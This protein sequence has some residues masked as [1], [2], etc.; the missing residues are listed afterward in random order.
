MPTATD[1]ALAMIAKH[2]G[3]IRTGEA[4]A[5]GIHPRTLYA[6]RDNGTLIALARGLY[7]LADLPPV[8]DPDLALVAG[9]IPHGVICLISALAIHDLT[10]QIPH[11]V[12]V[13]IP[14][15]ARYPVYAG[16]PL[17]IYRFALA[18]Y[19]AGV[20]RHNVD[21]VNTKVYV[22]EKTLA[23][24]FKYRNKIG[25][26]I[27]LEALDIYRHRPG[28]SMQTILE[29]ARVNRVESRIRPYLEAKA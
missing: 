12:D 10:T 21:G 8:G 19:R 14:R 18:S 17:T 28:V 5:R 22:A 27:F 11:R 2:G 3:V 16:A 15:T 25:L 6:L 20:T 29:Y 4:L 9:R 1:K 13:A 26:D 24:C 23:D 7:R